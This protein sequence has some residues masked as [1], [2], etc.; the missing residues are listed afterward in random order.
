LE[1]GVTPVANSAI[2][3]TTTNQYIGLNFIIKT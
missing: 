3:L 2:S 1:D